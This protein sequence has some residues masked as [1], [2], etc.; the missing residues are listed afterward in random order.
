M[1]LKK[2]IIK[3]NVYFIT[4]ED[5]NLLEIISEILEGGIKLIQ[6]RFKKGDDKFHLQQAIEI[7]KLC[8]KYQATFIINDRIDIALAANADGVHLGQND[9]NIESARKLLGPTKIIG[10]SANNSVDIKKAIKDGCDYLGI[11]PI[12]KTSTKKNKKSLGIKAIKELTK[13]IT[14]PWFAIGG[15]D[16]ENINFLK[17]NGITKVAI[18]SGLVKSKKPKEEAAIILKNLS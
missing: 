15:I 1:G 3:N 8:K 12:F 9:L 13:D 4:P 7:N 18:I 2:N 5:P 14:I 6:Y 11:G 10:I 17:E 16:K